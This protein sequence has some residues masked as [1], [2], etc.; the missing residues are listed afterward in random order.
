MQLA[1]AHNNKKQA[2]KLPVEELSLFEEL[3]ILL[4]ED[5]KKPPKGFEKFF[6]KKEERDKKPDAAASK[7]GNLI[8]LNHIIFRERRKER[9]G[10]RVNK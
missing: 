2:M 8:K 10:G 5:G 4:S 1:L 6:K 3:A 9:A 7:D